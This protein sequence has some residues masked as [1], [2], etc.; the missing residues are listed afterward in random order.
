LFVSFLSRL[1]I[2]EYSISLTVATGAMIAARMTKATRVEFFRIFFFLGAAHFFIVGY[3]QTTDGHLKWQ[4]LLCQ[5]I[6]CGIG[7]SGQGVKI[8]LDFF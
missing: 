1:S 4:S 5:C 3:S 7:F 6:C 8:L 2:E